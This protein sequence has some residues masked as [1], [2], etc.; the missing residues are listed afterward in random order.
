M[1][2]AQAQVEQLTL[3]TGDQQLAAYD[4]KVLAA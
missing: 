3:V 2:V 1:L 4:V